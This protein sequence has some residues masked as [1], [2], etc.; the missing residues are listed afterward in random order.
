MVSLLLSG[1]AHA[2]TLSD[3]EVDNFNVRIGTQIFAPKYHFTTNSSL[4]EAADL[5]REMGSDVIKFY[6]SKN[7]SPYGIKLPSSA[8][9]LTTLT[10]FEPSYRRVFDMPFR[11]YVLWAYC[12]SAPSDAYWKNGI[13]SGQA[14]S[15]Y[16]EMYAFASYLL[17]TYNNSGK[18][19]YLGHWEGDWYLLPNYDASVNPSTNTI[20]GMI[21]WLNIR[22]KA[23]DDAMQKVPHTNV[24][25]YVYTEANRVRDAMVNGPANNQ[26]VI[27]AV[28][29][30]VTNLD[31]VSWSSYDGMDLPTGVL[32][33]T[34]NYME[35]RMP[36]NKAAAI[37]GRRVFIGEYGWGGT[38]DSKAQEPV[39]RDYIRRLLPW[40]PRFILFWQMYD[41]E[42]RAYWLVDSNHV[43]TPCFYLHQNFANRARLIS[44]QFKETNGRLPND[45]EISTLT[46]PL[47]SAPVTASARLTV[48]NLN[49]IELTTNAATVKGSVWQGLYGDEQATVRVCWGSQDGGTVLSNWEQSAIVGVNTNFNPAVFSLRLTN[50]PVKA[51]CYYRFQASNAGSEAWA[52]STSQFSTDVFDPQPWGYRMKIGFT[53]YTRGEPL[54]NFPVLVEL[55]TNVPGFSYRQFASATGNDL[56]FVDQSGNHLTPHEIDEWNTNGT[57]LIWVRVPALSSTSDFI[58]AYWGNPSAM[59]LP[60]TSTN[61]SVWSENFELVWHL[62][63]T[64]FPF[65]DSAAKHPAITGSLPASSSAGLIGRGCTFNGASS[66]LNAGV[67]NLGNTFTLSA[68]VKMDA[69]ASSIRS[70]WASK[71][72]GSSTPGLALY[73]N[74]WGTSDQKLILE[75]GNGSGAA[76]AGTDTNQVTPGQWHHIAAAINRTAGTAQ[77]FIDGEDRTTSTSALTGFPNQT[78]LFLGRFGDPTYFFKGTMDEARIET[79]LRSANWIWAS[80]MTTVSNAT[81][82]SYEAPQAQRPALSASLNTTTFSLQ[83]PGSGTGYQLYSA[84][85]LMQPVWVPATNQAVLVN[86][87]WQAL[88]PIDLEEMRFYR[89][90]Q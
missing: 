71:A 40:S 61:S 48:S 22:Q 75:T 42:G 20:R 81:F 60:A 64:A 6:V 51:P 53:G 13:S 84:T 85:N 35:T 36:T 7:V 89:L 70:I 58:W 86:G 88:L 57:S 76:Y 65:A 59:N 21:D 32:W 24:A 63:E 47:L 68:W 87:Q 34:L 25:V 10:R 4:V 33:A 12:F 27:N 41:N 62:K 79:A 78:N 11:H 16:N 2:V 69:N 83:W 8:T 67:V 15:E 31:F 5:M 9:S 77:F 73:A 43:K 55:S 19:F 14:Q 46:T 74:S 56:C 28:V 29:P 50:L 82:T 90:S 44:A 23:I 52:P 66:Y 45:S 17:T 18:S 54:I 72:G 1:I 80:W 49:V 3:P 39:T 30:G 37:Q 26:R 38:R